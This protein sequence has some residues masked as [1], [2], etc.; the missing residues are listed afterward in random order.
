MTLTQR[1]RGSASDF[2]ITKISINAL[3]SKRER[4][5]A[6]RRQESMS[7]RKTQPLFRPQAVH[8]KLFR[9]EH[10]GQNASLFSLRFAGRIILTVKCRFSIPGHDVGEKGNLHF[11]FGASGFV[12]DACGPCKSSGQT[13]YFRSWG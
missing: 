5:T 13:Q 1:G 4:L 9:Y 8:F 10:I 6:L 7:K 12:F 2:Q 11:C 3:A